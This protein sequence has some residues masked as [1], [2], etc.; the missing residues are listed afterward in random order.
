MQPSRPCGLFALL[1]EAKRQTELAYQFNP[2]SYT[3]AGFMA[4]KAALSLYA[5]ETPERDAS[6][7]GVK[8]NRTILRKWQHILTG[9]LT[10]RPFSVS[11]ACAGCLA[12]NLNTN[13]H[14]LRH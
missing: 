7:S 13:A 8:I 5:N 1:I 14:P 10:S 12:L 11:C 9:V 2:G 3:F 4:C 6:P